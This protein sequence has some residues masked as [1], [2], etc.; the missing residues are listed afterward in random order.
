MRRVGATYMDVGSPPTRKPEGISRRHRN[1]A[2]FFAGSRGSQGGG[3]EPPG[4]FTGD[5]VYREA[6]NVR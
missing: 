3:G 2:I 6:R 4:T 1:A 5:V